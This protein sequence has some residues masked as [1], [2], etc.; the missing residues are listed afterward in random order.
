MPCAFE[1]ILKMFSGI[2]IRSLC[3][4]SSASTLP[5]HVFMCTEELPCCNRSGPLGTSNET[6][7]CKA[8]LYSTKASFV[9]IC[10]SN[11]VPMVWPHGSGGQPSAN[12]CLISVYLNVKCRAGLGNRA[13]KGPVW[14]QVYWIYRQ[15]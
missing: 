7:Y 6:L 3:L 9:K 10:D 4:S 8:L 2:G 5:N 15:L 12:L 14:V 11:F 1:V 13:I